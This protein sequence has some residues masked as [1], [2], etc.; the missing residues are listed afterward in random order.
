MIHSEHS[1]HVVDGSHAH[2]SY[3]IQVY[4]LKEVIQP[5]QD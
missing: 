2:I 3:F 5:S 1:A 4:L